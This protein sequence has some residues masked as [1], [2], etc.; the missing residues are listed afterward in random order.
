MAYYVDFFHAFNKYIE[1]LPKD[2]ELKDKFMA[3]MKNRPVVV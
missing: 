2:D 1:E 3:S